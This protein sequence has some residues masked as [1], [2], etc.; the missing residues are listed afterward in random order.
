MK[1]IKKVL[2]LVTTLAML[3]TM[4]AATGLTAFAA[5]PTGSITVT[6]PV[7]DPNAD[8]TTYEAY[9]IFDMTTNGELKDGK[10]TAVAYTINSAW[11]DF[12]A[13]GA[14]GAGY[15]VDSDTDPASL[16]PIVVGGATKYI[17]ITESNVEAFAKA[18]FKYAQEK[19]VNATTSIQV[20]KGAKTVKFEN[21]A[22]GY[23]MVY[24]KGASVQDNGYTS[25]VSITNTAPDGEIAQ[26]AK[27]PG[28]QKEADDVSVEVGQ[29]V[30]YTLKSNVPDTTGY[31]KYEMSFADKTTDGLTFDGDKTIVVKIGS[32]TL[33]KDTD[34]T[35][36]TATADFSVTINMLKNTGTEAAPV[37][38][39]K[40]KYDDPIT[41]TYTATV[42][43][44]AIAVIDE[45][46][47]TLTYHND[48][49]DDTKKDTTPP[50]IVKTFSSKI[51]VNKVDG[52]NTETKLEG[53]KFVLKVKTVGA[54]SHQSDLEAGK[55]YYYDE[56]AKDVQWI[57]VPTADQTP[58]KLAKNENIT[59]AV[60]NAQG[61]T[62]DFKGLENGT[63]ELIE[64]EAPAG[65]NLPTETTEVV[66]N[67][68][69]SDPK[70]LTYSFTIKNN[71]GT[72]LPGTGGIG[73]TIF[74]ILGSLLVVG[75]GIVL[76]SRKRMQNNK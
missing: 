15:I 72:Q 1:R 6:S 5:D 65:Y 33:V 48:P 17:N 51:I 69:D 29:K 19:P 39:A 52:S 63:Y 4:V 27:W 24:P 42:N 8:N 55:F 43:E 28:L 54:D 49:K 53:A 76:V 64:V 73:T 61:V 56:D 21:L 20:A 31:S 67:G 57:E 36:S 2:A 44:D 32:A 12:F 50:V 40:Y 7:T 60:T 22:L 66:I 18:A 25:I 30:T 62:E 35:V 13:T 41:V 9:K 45:N 14:P 16:N 71:S 10:Y 46:H 23:Y 59:V 58:E 74:Y 11:T 37:W 38:E 34:Y 26:K 75:C 47:A 3:L 68:K 70:T